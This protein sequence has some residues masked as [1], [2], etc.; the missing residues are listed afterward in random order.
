MISEEDIINYPDKTGDYN[1]IR[2]LSNFNK[3][4][5][6][7]LVAFNPNIRE[8]ILIDNP[9]DRQYFTKTQCE[10]T[11]GFPLKEGGQDRIEDVLTLS[12][13]EV[14]FWNKMGVDPFYMYLEDSIKHVDA[15]WVEHNR[16]V[17]NLQADSIHNNEDEEII[18]TNGN[19]YAYHANIE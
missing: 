1:V 3:R 7:L 19:D 4:I 15:D 14:L 11:M 10:L 16:K 13:S 9:K 18:E 8:D 12:D 2:Y 5:E 6:P 17:L